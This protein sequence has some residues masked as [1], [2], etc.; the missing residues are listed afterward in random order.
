MKVLCVDGVKAGML[1]GGYP[2]IAKVEHEIYEGET[3]T[4]I[5]SDFIDNILGYMLQERSYGFYKASRFVPLSNQ[6]ETEL[7]KERQSET[8]CGHQ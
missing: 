6:D 2:V 4:V 8:V 1:S 7:I 3:Y 5:G